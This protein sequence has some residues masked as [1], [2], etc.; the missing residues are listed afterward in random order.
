MLKG[1]SSHTGASWAVTV[2][3]PPPEPGSTDIAFKNVLKFFT[4]ACVAML[5]HI[6]SPFLFLLL[7]LSHQLW[8]QGWGLQMGSNNPRGPAMFSLEPRPCSPPHPEFFWLLL[9]DR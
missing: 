8:S 7:L 6:P 1:R 4:K 3:C 9:C 5:P 2:L